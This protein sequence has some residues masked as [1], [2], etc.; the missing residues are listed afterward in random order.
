MNK[1]FIIHGFKGTPNGGWRPWLM[2]ELDKHD[3][4]ACSLAMPDPELPICKDWVDE[5]SKTVLA[6]KNDNLF[7]IGHSLGVPAILR[8][9]ENDNAKNIAGSVLVSGPSEKN[10]N[11]KI[12]SFLE[13]SFDFP[14][15]KTKCTRFKIIHGDN[16]PNVPLEDAK[17]LANELNAELAIVPN[18]GHLNGSSGWNSLPIC[19]EFLLKMLQPEK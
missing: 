6:N 5:I 9:L 4:F 11:A 15:I 3:V 8:Y 17:F 18:G 2:A 7:L 10:K 19:L 16:D 14:K 12:D 1:V 13:K